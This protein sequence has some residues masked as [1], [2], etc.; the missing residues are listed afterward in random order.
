MKMERAII[1]VL[2]AVIAAL[3]IEGATV[4][5]LC[6]ALLLGLVLGA[7]LGAAFVTDRQQKES[8]S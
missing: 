2:L 7:L 3:V 5:L 4:E 6:A 8:A 1:L